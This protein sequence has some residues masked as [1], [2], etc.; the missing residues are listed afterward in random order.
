MSDRLKVR[1]AVARKRHAPFAFEDLELEAPRADEVLVRVVAAGVC[2]TD[3][4]VRDGDI[5]TPLPVVLGHEGSGIVERVG[6]GVTRVAPGDH[7]VLTFNACGTCPNCVEHHTTYCHESYPRNFGA[8]RP[9]GTSPLSN[10][11]E[12]VGGNFFGQSS[13]ATHAIAREIN[14]VKVTKDVSLDMLGPLA[15]GIQ[16]G[17]GAV[18]NSFRMG[19]GRTFAV[20]GAGSVGLAGLMAAKVMCARTIIA[21]DTN[22][23]R[24]DI[25]RELGAT[26]VIDARSGNAAER[27]R[28]ITGYG[29]EFALDTTGVESVIEGA[30]QALAPRGLC[31]ILGASPAESRIS[32]RQGDMRGPGRRLMGIVEGDSDPQTFIPLMIELYRQGRFPFDKLITYYPFDRINEAVA[33]SETGRAIKPVVRMN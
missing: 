24:L 8:R 9:D 6:A 28:E 23:A 18:I 30:V 11:G 13:F 5:P 17:A 20:F 2:H 14:V 22:L 3:I 31:G 4:V 32:L 10:S 27:I 1:A 29:V 7:V 25:A 12:L 15:C 33:D 19:L 21:V 16:T 26:H